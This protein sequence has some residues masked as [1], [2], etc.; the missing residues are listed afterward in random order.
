M[1]IYKKLSKM[2]GDKRF[3][4]KPTHTRHTYINIGIWEKVWL[5][6]TKISGDGISP[7]W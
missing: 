4:E 2:G 7:G 5:Y 1:S 6:Y 3:E